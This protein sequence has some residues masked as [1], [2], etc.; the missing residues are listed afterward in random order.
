MKFDEK[1]LHQEYKFRGR[2][3]SARVDEIELPDGRP[4]IR[5]VCEHVG[6]VGVLPI[7]AEGN[8]ILVRQFRYPYGKVLCEI[9]AG[10]LDHGPE[11][12]QVCGMRELEEETG[13]TAGRMVPLGIS[14]PSP[15]FLDEITYLFAALDLTPGETHPDEGEFVEKITMPFRELEHRIAE[16][17]IRD[18]KT[19][20]A[21]YRA[22]LKGL[23]E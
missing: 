4:S 21:A 3:M 19:I 18:S 2:I 10:K 17:E 13:Y 6:G 9:P 15:G 1:T 14:Y 8:V 5:E 7:D 11:D 23:I 20:V 12:A 22:R 16:D